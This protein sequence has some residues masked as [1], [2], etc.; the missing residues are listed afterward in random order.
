MPDLSME[1]VV[2]VYERGAVRALDGVSLRI[3][4]GERVALIGQNGSGKTTLVRHLNGLLRPTSGHVS[5]AGRDTAPLRV[6]ELAR[7]VGLVFQ[8]PDRQICSAFAVR[9]YE[10]AGVN[11]FST[12][13]DA[14]LIAPFQFDVSPAFEQVWRA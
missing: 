6:A 11:A 8:D 10:R 2:H 3:A 9:W 5:L 7:S 13:E 14:D 4:A 1:S 12:R